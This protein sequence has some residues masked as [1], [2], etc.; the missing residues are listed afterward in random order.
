MTT[1]KGAIPYFQDVKAG[2][3]I[4]KG[5]F[6]QIRSLT[7]L[8]NEISFTQMSSENSSSSMC[9]L[10]ETEIRSDSRSDLPLPQKYVLK[11]IRGSI[12]N[13]CNEATFDAAAIDLVKE[14]RFLQLLSHHE[15][16]IGFYCTGGCEGSR[17]F[18][19]LIEKIEKTL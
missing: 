15:N 5:T 17:D 19:I 11:E 1:H 6:G 4:G 10:E 14:S 8:P 2:S 18:F 3:V 7:S 13:D 16:I 9:N 12:A